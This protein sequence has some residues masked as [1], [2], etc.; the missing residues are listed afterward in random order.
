MNSILFILGANFQVSMTIS[1]AIDWRNASGVFI[2]KKMFL[3]SSG[4][5][6]KDN[7]AGQD[8]LAHSECR[9]NIIQSLHNTCVTM[10]TGT[11]QVN[12]PY[13]FVRLQVGKLWVECVGG[14]LW[15]EWWKKL[16]QSFKSTKVTMNCT[17]VMSS[18]TVRFTNKTCMGLV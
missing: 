11:D 6:A 2:G 4:V 16:S 1:L 14:N 12:K 15:V 10:V 8:Y 3:L 13:R 9:R 5:V 17:I 18:R 7:I